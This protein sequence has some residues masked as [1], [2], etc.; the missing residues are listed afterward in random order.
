MPKVCSRCKRL[1]DGKFKCCQKCRDILNKSRKKRRERVA[2]AI[3]K[4]GYQYCRNCSRDF[5]L[6]HFQSSHSRRKTLTTSCASCRAIMSKSQRKKTTTTGKC[7][8]VF[9]DW[10][11]DKRCELCGYQGDNIEADH[12]PDRGQKIRRCCDYAWWRSHGGV[13]A[14]EVEL[15]KCRPLCRFCHRLV[16]QQERGLTK[17]RKE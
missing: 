17:R 16:S 1:T 9:W 8:Q 11:K 7:K 14:L 10:K 6:S 5:P 4:D 13:S 2:K 3:A 15:K 12:R